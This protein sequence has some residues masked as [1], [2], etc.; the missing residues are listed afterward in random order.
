RLTRRFRQQAREI[1]TCR[2]F[3]LPVELVIKTMCGN[4]RWALMPV[5]LIF[6]ANGVKTAPDSA[7]KFP[8]FF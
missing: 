2:S 7:F 4:V 8:R 3:K 6:T 5:R 1:R